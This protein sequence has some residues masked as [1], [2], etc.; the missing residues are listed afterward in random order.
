[1]P[2]A[3]VLPAVP[4]GRMP[5]PYGRMQHVSHGPAHH[6]QPSACGGTTPVAATG[7]PPAGP[8]PMVPPTVPAA[9]HPAP[10]A[11]PAPKPQAESVR[12]QYT[13]AQRSQQ[14][15]LTRERVAVGQSASPA[16]PVAPGEAL[17]QPA[18]AAPTEAPPAP[19]A[20]G[21]PVLGVLAP[22]HGAQSAPVGSGDA[23]P[24]RGLPAAVPAEPM[25]QEAA[26]VRPPDIGELLAQALDTYRREVAGGEWAARAATGTEADVGEL[27]A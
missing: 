11:P 25:A 13:E 12:A 26:V 18:P 1:M 22:T 3:Q 14:A 16:R 10:R 4:Y 24:M 23:P 6:P 5:V 19:V 9:T 15:E 27:I 21:E 17:P 8:P 20:P 7:S 2:P